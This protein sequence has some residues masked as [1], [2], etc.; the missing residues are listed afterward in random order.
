M[1]FDSYFLKADD[2]WY[3]I[4]VLWKLYR[5]LKKLKK[6]LL[7]E[8]TILKMLMGFDSYFLKAD[9]SYQITVSSWCALSYTMYLS[10]F[11]WS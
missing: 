8:I 10:M 7:L 9:D 11:L 5:N 2:P 6:T 4:D 1:G 3:L